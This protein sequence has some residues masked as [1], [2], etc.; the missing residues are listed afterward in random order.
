MGEVTPD[1]LRIGIAVDGYADL[2]SQVDAYCGI[3]IE[4]KREAEASIVARAPIVAHPVGEKVPGPAERALAAEVNRGRM[5]H[6]AH[7]IQTAMLE[8][9]ADAVHIRVFPVIR[10][11]KSSGSAAIVKPAEQHPVTHDV[12]AA[13]VADDH[14]AV[15]PPIV[16]PHEARTPPMLGILGIAHVDAVDIGGRRGAAAALWHAGNGMVRIR[17]GGSDEMIGDVA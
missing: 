10:A 4:V 8:V 14:P 3:R 17:P 9:L 15:R 7:P 16:V 13:S 5:V 12:D 11:A 2:I 6:A 1:V